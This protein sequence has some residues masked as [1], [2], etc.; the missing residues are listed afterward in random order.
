M[1]DAQR[2][3]EE[4]GK[5][6]HLSFWQYKVMCRARLPSYQHPPLFP[7]KVADLPANFVASDDYV[8]YCSW[9]RYSDFE[10][11]GR[12]LQEE[13]LHLVIPPVP[14][15]E[16]DGTMD[17]FQDLFAKQSESARNNALTKKRIRHFQLFL[18]VIQKLTVLHE[19][20][21]LKAFVAM[22]EPEWLAYKE[23]VQRLKPKASTWT[24]FT[25]L[26]SGG[27]TAQHAV[28][29]DDVTRIGAIRHK[30]SEMAT[31]LSV[32][33]KQAF[34]MHKAAHQETQDF[35]DLDVLALG[36][37]GPI[38]ETLVFTGHFVQQEVS[39]GV[40]SAYGTVRYV[41]PEGGFAWVEWNES[42]EVTRVA[43]STLRYPSSGV[44]DPAVFA[45]NEQTM[46]IESFFTYV[47]RRNEAKDTER[48]ID[49]L[50][51]AQKYCSAAANVV[52]AIEGIE[53]TRRNKFTEAEKKKDE[54]MKRALLGECEALYTKFTETTKQFEVSF[55]EYFRPWQ[56]HALHEIL[57]LAGKVSFNVLCD[58]DWQNRLQRAEAALPL[59]FGIPKEAE[60]FRRQM[61][62][63]PVAPVCEGGSQLPP[64]TTTNPAL[65]EQ[66]P[67]PPPANEKP[68][69]QPQP[70]GST[71]K[72]KVSQPPVVESWRGAF[73]LPEDNEPPPLPPSPAAAPP[74]ATQEGV[75]CY[76]APQQDN[77]S[78]G[79]PA[80][81]Q[82][83]PRAQ[84]AHELSSMEPPPPPPAQPSPA[85][86]KETQEAPP[87]GSASEI[88]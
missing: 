46:Q 7:R 44:T 11:L 56:Q 57:Q 86:P 4:G 72:R 14:D 68:Q 31:T 60:A 59:T 75:Q 74:R 69:P 84:E 50:W 15:K 29:F 67:L 16:T 82:Q 38:P 47:T 34:N 21:H 17:K 85:A 65:P 66:Q 12:E 64:V 61:N 2:Q 40:L 58:D 83:P 78:W 37:K 1:A 33:M 43:I 8:D 87:A 79:S 10:W 42:K 70:Q 5:L 30:Q 81:P 73:G 53:R 20:T 19:S 27:A 76:E 6:Q 22:E 9:H 49:E 36:N 54:F 48:L 28:I 25:G 35:A 26:F 23:E 71:S 77:S 88:D 52:D 32:C 3:F 80:K 24:W 13:Y 62:P 41:E 18:N 55:G 51:F 63:A 39:P 45:I